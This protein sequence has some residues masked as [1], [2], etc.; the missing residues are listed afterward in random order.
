ML[1]LLI[2]LYIAHTVNSS[3]NLQHINP[4]IGTDNSL[5][6]PHGSR[7]GYAGMIPSTGVPFAM[8]RWTPMTQLNNVSKCPYLYSQEVIYGFLGTHQ[9]AIWMGESAQVSVSAGLGSEVNTAFFDR[10]LTYSHEDEFSSP[11]LY[12][13]NLSNPENAGTNLSPRLPLIH[14]HPHAITSNF[15]IVYMYRVDGMQGVLYSPKCL[16]LRE[17]VI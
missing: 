4:L 7:A 16:Q 12:Q 8:T 2:M 13:V 1:Q 3:S 6:N 11:H 10:G 17:W 9:P 15:T 5:T 14:S